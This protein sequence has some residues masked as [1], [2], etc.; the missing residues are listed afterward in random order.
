MK[1]WISARAA[2]AGMALLIGLAGCRDD[3]H[4]ERLR[5]AGQ[6]PT[7]Q[8]LMK[9]ADVES[10]ARKFRQCAACH[11]IIEGASDR[12]GPNLFGVFGQPPGT[13]RSRYG[14][15]AALIG[16]GGKWDEKAL[17]A[18]IGA[19]ASVVPGTTMQFPGVK[20]PLDRADLIAYLRTQA[21]APR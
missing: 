7:L 16:I 18:W 4:D 1:A 6:D 15:T 19:P 14:Y 10:G 8:E 9:V 11:S 5:E 17:D 13:N 21:R 2:F 3:R 20:D 12:G